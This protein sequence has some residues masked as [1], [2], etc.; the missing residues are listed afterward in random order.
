MLAAHWLQ[1][2][3][4]QQHIHKHMLIQHWL[5]MPITQQHLLNTMLIQHY[6]GKQHTNSQSIAI[7]TIILPHLAYNDLS[8]HD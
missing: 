8:G 7:P 4:N 3:I 2:R 5:H 6:Q 1:H